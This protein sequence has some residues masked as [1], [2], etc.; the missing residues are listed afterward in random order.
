MNNFQSEYYDILAEWQVDQRLLAKDQMELVKIYTA[1][2]R[3][4]E[5][6]GKTIQSTKI[7]DPLIKLSLALQKMANENFAQAT[8][9]DQVL[10][11]ISKSEGEG[12]SEG[13]G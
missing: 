6:K 12:A 1:K 8:A 2:I 10:D 11:F 4:I 7:I 13:E 9:I 5:D 3:A